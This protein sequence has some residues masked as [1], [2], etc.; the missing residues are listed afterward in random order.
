MCYFNKLHL[1]VVNAMKYQMTK[2][3]GVKLASGI[4]ETV[5]EILKN[6]TE[7]TRHHCI[8]LLRKLKLL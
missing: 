7:L 3:V 5:S 2:H 1:Q 6:N 8:R 4:L